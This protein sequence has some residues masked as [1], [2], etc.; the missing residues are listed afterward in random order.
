M[1]ALALPVDMN[2]VLAQI[3]V[4]R[5]LFFRVAEQKPIECLSNAR[6]ETAFEVN[7]SQFPWRRRNAR[8]AGSLLSPCETPKLMRENALTEVG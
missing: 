1:H 3:Q 7:E 2:G 6:G 4:K 8:C 5:H